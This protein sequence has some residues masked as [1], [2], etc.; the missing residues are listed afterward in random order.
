MT[1]YAFAAL[2]SQT[3]QTN[4]CSITTHRQFVGWRRS[5]NGNY[6]AAYGSFARSVL[7][8]N[9]GFAIEGIVSIIVPENSQS[10]NEKEVDGDHKPV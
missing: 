10:L 9:P 1:T 3:T 7:S 8:E 2:L 6:D 4:G 5:N